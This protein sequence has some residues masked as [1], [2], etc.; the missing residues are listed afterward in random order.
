M[1]DARF[2]PVTDA[3]IKGLCVIVH[4][5]GDPSGVL[6]KCNCIETLDIFGTKI[7]KTG[8]EMVLTNLPKLKM[9]Q[10][11]FVTELLC[12]LRGTALEHLRYSTN[13]IT[14]NRGM[15][16]G[17]VGHLL[18]LEKIRELNIEVFEDMGDVT[19]IGGFL[20]VLNQFGSC[21]IQ[22]TI[23]NIFNIAINIPAIVKYF[24]KLESLTLSNIDAHNYSKDEPIDNK[25]IKTEYVLPNLRKL[26]V[27]QCY[28]LQPETLNLLLA[29]PLLEKIETGLHYVLN[30][31]PV[32]VECKPLV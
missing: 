31:N 26:K 5:F 25:R 22:L 13:N 8:I 29:S 28:S 23:K 14:L 3:G 2:C 17:S 12:E 15:S 21:L 24:Q 11:N 4:D 27:I 7:S 16:D 32:V 10:C 18:K 9:F 1:L 19:F 6:S 20:P 30:V